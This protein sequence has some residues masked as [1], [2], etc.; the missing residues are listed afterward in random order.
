MREFTWRKRWA[1][2]C[3]TRRSKSLLSQTHPTAGWGVPSAGAGR[4]LQ[5]PCHCRCPLWGKKAPF[6]P[7]VLRGIAFSGVFLVC[8]RAAADFRSTSEA[9]STHPEQEVT[10][11]GRSC[12]SVWQC[13]RCNRGPSH[14]PPCSPG[15]T[16]KHRENSIYTVWVCVCLCVWGPH[17]PM[18]KPA[19]YAWCSQPSVTLNP[20]PDSSKHWRKRKEQVAYL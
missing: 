11:A 19:R 1:G 20:Q 5:R 16:W 15:G 14:R 9:T 13:G 12:S 10:S 8:V 17:L 18:I 6:R 2:S 7:L 4:C 3:Q